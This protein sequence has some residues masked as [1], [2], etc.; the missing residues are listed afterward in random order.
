MVSENPWLQAFEYLQNAEVLLLL[1]GAGMSADSGIPT[2]RGED[3]SWGR[4]EKEFNKHITELMTPQFIQEN[5]VYMWKKFSRGLAHLKTVEP[6][7]GYH[8]LWQWI[9]KFDYQYFIITS[10]VDGQFQKAGF[11]PQQVYEVHGASGYLQCAT[12]CWDK[13][14]Q[15][16]YSIYAEVNLDEMNLP[17]CPNCGKLVRPN[18]YIFQDKT[19]VPT[20]VR[21][22]KNRLEDFLTIH[23]NKKIV[24]LEI[25]AGAVVKTIR[26][27]TNR[28]IRDYQAQVIRINPNAGDAHI[29]EPHLS[30]IDTGLKALQKL[31]E[32]VIH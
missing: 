19:F 15:E 10:N 13:V 2:Y 8:I 30:L 23:Q 11:S 4:W 31:N 29:V 6:H 16:D 27:W 22:Q 12:P 18:V 14:W 17:Q 1:T 20:R 3:G 28:L 7:L 24:V 25:G 26:H 5:P 9:Q 21:A 32:F